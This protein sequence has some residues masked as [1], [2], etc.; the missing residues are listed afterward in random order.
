MKKHAK[1]MQKKPLKTSSYFTSFISFSLALFS[2]LMLASICYI[3]FILIFLLYG[4]SVCEYLKCPQGTYP[5]LYIQFHFIM[6]VDFTTEIINSAACGETIDF[7]GLWCIVK[8]LML[9]LL[10]YL[11]QTALSTFFFLPFCMIYICMIYSK[12]SWFCIYILN[13]CLAFVYCNTTKL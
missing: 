3:S 13:P 6:F 2:F 4:F 5:A 7:A 12:S 11:S 10:M 1:K 8:T 9:L